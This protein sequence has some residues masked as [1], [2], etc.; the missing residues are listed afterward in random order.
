MAHVPQV[1]N[2]VGVIT[3]C[4]RVLPKAV[5]TAEADYAPCC[6]VP[7]FSGMGEGR[8]ISIGP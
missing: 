6:G 4:C 8:P 5:V 3:T 1:I 2:A 7:P